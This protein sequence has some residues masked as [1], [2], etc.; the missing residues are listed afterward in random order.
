M[1]AT[2]EDIENA[3][4]NLAE[5]RNELAA[6]ANDIEEQVTEIRERYR[7]RVFEL[8]NRVVACE[9]TLRD[10]IDDNRNLFAKPKTR[11]F[12][13]IKVGVVQGKTSLK[14]PDPETVIAGIRKHRSTEVD[15]FIETKEVVR[16]TALQ[17]LTTSELITLGCWVEGG[18]HQVVVNPKSS[19]TEKLVDAIIRDA[20]TSGEQKEAA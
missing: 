17:Q 2:L 7:A 3:T 9:R 15:R 16:K 19:E 8:A 6:V 14:F 20:V 5:A 4:H 13:G 18:G 12:H 10:R 1:K 11:T